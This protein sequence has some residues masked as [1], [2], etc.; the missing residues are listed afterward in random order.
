MTLKKLLKVF[1]TINLNFIGRE[2]KKQTEYIE[3]LADKIIECLP[4]EPFVSSST[5]AKNVNGHYLCWNLIG[6]VSVREQGEYKSIDITFA[7]VTNK[8][9]STFLDIQGF[10]L[11]A[12]NNCG[13]LLATKVEEENMDE[14]E[15]E[16]KKKNAVIEFKSVHSWSKTKDWSIELPVGEV[17]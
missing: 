14:Y 2:E 13:V 11:A 16:D 9:K 5:P 6:A 10:C 8:K 15:K 17:I 12:L 7:D 3:S 4:Q 1:F